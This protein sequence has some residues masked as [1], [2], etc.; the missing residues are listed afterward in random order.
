MEKKSF[1]FPF[2]FLV[3]IGCLEDTFPFEAGSVFMTDRE[4]QPINTHNN[5]SPSFKKLVEVPSF[6]QETLI[7]NNYHHCVISNSCSWGGE[8]MLCPAAAKAIAHT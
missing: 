3:W 8:G 2:F 1:F 5:F 4:L 7:T 6:T